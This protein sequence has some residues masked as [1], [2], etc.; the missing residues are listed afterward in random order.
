MHSN[1]FLTGVNYWPRNKAMYWWRDF[2]PHE[3]EDEFDVIADLGMD[4]VRIF[5][6]WDDWQETPDSV[7]LDRLADL[8]TVCDI[9]SARSLGLDIT[10]FTGHMSG[11]NWAP[12]WLLDTSVGYPSPQV[13]QVISGG[14]PVEM[15][16]R[17][18]FD[19]PTAVEAERLLLRTVVNEYR[20]HDAV[21]MWNLGNEPDNFAW[22]TSAAQGTTWVKEMT[23][24]IREIDPNH[25]VTTG[26]HTAS[27]LSNNGLRVDDVFADADIAVMHGYPMYIDWV[28]D[29]LDSDFVPFLSALTSALSGISCLAEEWGGCTAPRGEASQV[30]NWTAYGEP[31]SQFM[32]SEDD[33]ASYVAAVLPK[34]VASGSAGSFM[35]CFADYAED[36]W[37]RA[38]CDDAG[39]RHE[40]HFGLVRPDGSLKPHAEV[41]RAFAAT[42]PTRMTVDWTSSLGVDAATYYETPASSA[43]SA[44][45]RYK[46]LVADEH[47]YSPT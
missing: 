38:P 46:S 16:Y 22:P 42:Q 34:L 30:W 25:L 37:D 24:L 7:S 45:E 2:D 8:G 32:A 21:W 47:G 29:P 20:D 17:N 28:E 35:W 9:A 1:R 5:L 18:M 11:P 13:H 4:V 14:K 15:P 19:D 44:F 41:I 10:F 3:V 31:R 39:A 43:R 27:L 36:L 23:E 40:R 6:L 26:L 33:F 12:R